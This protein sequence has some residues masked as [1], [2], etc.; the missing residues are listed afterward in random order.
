VGR[1]PDASTHLHKRPGERGQAARRAE[2]N[3]LQLA[4][5]KR[6]TVT[7]STPSAEASDY[8]D[9]E[10]DGRLARLVCANIGEQIKAAGRSIE[11]VA[12][13]ARMSPVQLRS[14]LDGFRGLFMYELVFIAMTLGIRTSVLFV[15]P[16]VGGEK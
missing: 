15:D 2:K 6:P 5:K 7:I 14:S 4:R 3:S 12:P 1:P 16:T 9:P 11:D 13:A 8:G 10:N